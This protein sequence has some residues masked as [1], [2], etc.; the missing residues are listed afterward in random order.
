MP[1]T[2]T[3]NLAG[4]HAMAAR[5]PGRPF[6]GAAPW[7]LSGPALLLFCAMLLVP[8]LLTGL[9]SLHA[10]DGT[11]GVLPAMTAANYLEILGDSYYHEIFLRTAGMALA[12][13]V[14]AVVFGVPETLILS[15][16]RSPWRG[17]FLI[18][19]LGPLLISVVVRTLGW[20]ILMGNNGLINETLQWL[21]LVDAPV[22]LV[23]TQTGVIIALTHVMMPFMVISVWA[24]LQKLDPQVEQ[25]GQAFGASPFTVFRRVILPQILPGILSGSIIV[26][27]LSASAFATPAI[28]GG[29]RLKVVATAAYDEFLNTLNWPLGAAI[30]VLLLIANVIVIVG[31]NRLVERRF[32]QVFEA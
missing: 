3:P 31:C 7:L 16:M 25:A 13:T 30:A 24:S 15:R 17:L 26:F 29:R 9:L 27:A 8:L 5:A 28:L 23:F 11:R 14:L 6:A 18:V 22:K 1:D 20:A 32:R 19:I 2:A 4:A 21:G 12:V 10:F